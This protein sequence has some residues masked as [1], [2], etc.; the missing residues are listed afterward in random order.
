MEC[1]QLKEISLLLCNH[2]SFP[3]D[4]C[5]YTAVINTPTCCSDGSAVVQF[6]DVEKKPGP[7]LGEMSG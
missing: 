7:N 6:E 2:D 3:S 4:V 1:L 5:F